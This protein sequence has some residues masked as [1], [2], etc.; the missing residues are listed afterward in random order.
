MTDEQTIT[1]GLSA[2]HLMNDQSFNAIYEAITEQI[3]KEILA[4]PLSDTQTR[5]DLYLTFHGMRSFL[6]YTNMFR[7]AKDQ[8]VERLNYEHESDD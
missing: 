5:Q 1:L 3:S 8:V 2:E 6:N 4:T 7:T